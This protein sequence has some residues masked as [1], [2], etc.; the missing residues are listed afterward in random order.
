MERQVDHVVRTACHEVE[1]SRHTEAD[2]ADVVAEH[3]GDGRLELRD[4][5]LLGLERR[6]PLVPA[7]HLAV[8]RDDPG[9][10]LRPAE[11]DADRVRIAH[12][13]RVP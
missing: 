8:P 2:C 1:R 10:D 3:L 5:R 11:V 12:R 13:E 9:E 6:H 4:E 7:Q